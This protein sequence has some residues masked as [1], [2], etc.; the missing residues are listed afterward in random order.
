M[1]LVIEGIAFEFSGH[2]LKICNEWSGANPVSIGTDDT[3]RL[4]DFLRVGVDMPSP[5]ERILADWA[6]HTQPKIKIKPTEKVSDPEDARFGIAVD[7]WVNLFPNLNIAGL[8]AYMSKR[9]GA[10]EE[11]NR[12]G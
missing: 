12:E 4:I 2:A 9:L 11:S 6:S 3:L 8:L 10:A 5:M 1:K 7:V